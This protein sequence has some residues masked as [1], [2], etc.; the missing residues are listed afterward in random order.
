MADTVVYLYAVTDADAPDPAVPAGVDG[1]P[2]RRVVAGPLAAVVSSVDAVRFGEE[3]LQR[4][5]EDLRWL[6]ATARAHH[7][8]V[9]AVAE[10]GP[11]APVRLATVYL[12]DE[13][14]R[15]LLDE[16]AAAFTAALDRVR[17]RVEWGVKGF[18]TPS[19]AAAPAEPEPERGGGGPGASYLKRRL[20][21]RDR[22]TRGQEAAFAAAEEA[23][24][25]LAAAALAHRTY[26]PQDRRLTGR[27]E[28]MVLNAAYLV[29]ADAGD[30]LRQVVEERSTG[31]VALE[32][33]G[34][35]APYSFATLEEPS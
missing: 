6:E 18:A 7:A 34:P 1:A 12:D 32:L 19:A 8:V 31:A 28:E 20:A 25:A 22:A 4:S 9:G 14:V 35:W 13:R 30:A 26:K 5:L 2:V 11:V 10:N 33:T 23:H 24:R 29:D 15:A 3:A 17:G 21:Q 27:A 16:R